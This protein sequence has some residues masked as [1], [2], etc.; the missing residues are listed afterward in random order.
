MNNTKVT[1]PSV[2]AIAAVV[3]NGAVMRREFIRVGSART[4]P[5]CRSRFPH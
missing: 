1:K 4:T 5:S 2:R 3:L